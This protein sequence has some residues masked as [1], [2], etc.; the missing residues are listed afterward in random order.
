M[1]LIKLKKSFYNINKNYLDH[2]KI[3]A[4]FHTWDL[5]SK[6]KK[7]KSFKEKIIIF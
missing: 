2:I 6:C 7:R 1:A 4:N 3:D 5:F